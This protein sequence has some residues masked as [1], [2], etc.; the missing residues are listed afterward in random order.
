MGDTRRQAGPEAADVR[1]VREALG[2]ARAAS[3]QG[4]G[5]GDGPP[6]GKDWRGADGTAVAPRCGGGDRKIGLSNAISGQGGEKI[7]GQVLIDYRVVLPLME[8]S[9]EGGGFLEGCGYVYGAG[10]C[11]GPLWRFRLDHVLV[12]SSGWG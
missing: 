2:A 5:G 1:V 11:I 12:D 6:T 9:G 4:A 7:P 10:T 8:A 3:A